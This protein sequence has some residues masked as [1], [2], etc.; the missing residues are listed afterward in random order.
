MLCVGCP[1]CVSMY[2]CV[3]FLLH[4]VLQVWFYTF[5]CRIIL[6]LIMVGILKSSPFSFIFLLNSWMWNF[7]I[8]LLKTTLVCYLL[9]FYWLYLSS[10]SVIY[11]DYDLRF[12]PIPFCAPVLNVLII[13]GRE[14]RWFRIILCTLWP[15]D[16][17]EH[18]VWQEQRPPSGIC[19]CWFQWLWSCWQSF[20]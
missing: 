16:M 8:A 12:V 17:C 18:H 20:M 11:R 1:S 2:R 13:S 9:L 19:L 15:S 4:V 10:C 3:I 14:R 7:A 6:L 5:N